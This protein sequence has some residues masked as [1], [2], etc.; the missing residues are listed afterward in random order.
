MIEC[1]SG[2]ELSALTLRDDR[3]P[4]Q[5]L[6]VMVN[7]PIRFSCDVQNRRENWEGSK[8]LIVDPESYREMQLDKEGPPLRVLYCQVSDFHN[9]TNFSHF[10]SNT[11]LS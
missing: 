10:H 8:A 4:N 5:N 11:T 2:P 9:M 6:L 3:I 1:T 7:G